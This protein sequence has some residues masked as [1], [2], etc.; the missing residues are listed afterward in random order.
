MLVKIVTSNHKVSLICFLPNYEWVISKGSKI[1][2]FE[3]NF[4]FS[5]KYY[6]NPKKKTKPAFYSN[7]LNNLIDNKQQPGLNLL[8]TLFIA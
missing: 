8:K 2:A 6:A 7:H 4:S 5:L 1:L 3:F